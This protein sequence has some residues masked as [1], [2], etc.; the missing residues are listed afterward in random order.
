MI[1]VGGVLFDG[2]A[3]EDRAFVW[4]EPDGRDVVVRSESW[5][6]G[7]EHW[8]GSDGVETALRIAEP[9]LVVLAAA[10]VADDPALESTAPA[11]QILASAYRGDS[12]ATSHL[13]ERLDALGLRAQFSMR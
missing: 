10:L 13:R 7:V 11:I 9:E 8:F 6:P 4:I 3:G 2:R 1:A 12:A 5:G